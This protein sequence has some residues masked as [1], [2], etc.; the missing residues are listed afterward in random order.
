MQKHSKGFRKRTTEVTVF[1]TV[2]LLLRV[3]GVLLANTKI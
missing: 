2:K 3:G 1:C